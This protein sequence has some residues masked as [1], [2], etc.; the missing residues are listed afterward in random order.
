LLLDEPTASLDINYQRNIFDLI[1]DLNERL[2]MSVLAVSHDL[3]L[4]SQYCDR[5]ILLNDGKIYSMGEVDDVITKENISEVYNTDV[6]IKY[7]PITERPY[8]IIVPRKKGSKQKIKSDFKVH[9][10]SGGGTG[11]KIMNILND[12]K[13]NVSCGVLNRGDSD[14][15]E[16]KR[17]NFD[18][19]EIPPFAPI[20]KKAV[21]KNKKKIKNADLIIVSGTPFGW[22]NLDNI[23]V[24]NNFENK[25][26]IFIDDNLDKRDFTDGE[27]TQILSE[28]QKNN[29]VYEINT[30]KELC[31]FL[32][33]KYEEILYD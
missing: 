26:I 8:V 30:D 4:I 32:N 14:W 16:A 5:L 27:F 1:S 2:D 10:I 13:V 9:L 22:G 7:N 25:D 12:L 23:K 15:E 20:D 21:A 11:K 28:I 6:D 19:V 24:L 17:L 29:N 3:N 33:T 18:I 31:N